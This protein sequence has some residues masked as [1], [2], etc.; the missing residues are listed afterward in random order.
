MVILILFIILLYDIYDVVILLS[1]TLRKHTIDLKT[2]RPPTSVFPQEF[3][4]EDFTWNSNTD[5]SY[6]DES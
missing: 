2:N 4:I 5:E 6:L 1:M 3:F